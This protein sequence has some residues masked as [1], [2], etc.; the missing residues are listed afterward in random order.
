MWRRLAAKCV[1]LIA[2]GEAKLA[3]GAKQVGAGLEAGIEGAIHHIAE[4]WDE[5]GH[6]DEWG[7]L[8][9]DARNAFNEADRWAML[10]TARHRWPSGCRFLFNCYCHFG[11]CLTTSANCR[12]LLAY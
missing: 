11:M 12:Y 5:L 1:I 3:C 2:G 8:L 9:V 7:V 4:L 6:E 10:W